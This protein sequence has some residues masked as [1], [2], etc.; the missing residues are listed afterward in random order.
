[1]PQNKKHNAYFIWI[2]VQLPNNDKQWYCVS[3]VL[4]HALYWERDKN[5][6]KYWKNSLIGNYIN[7]ATSNYV[8]NQARLTVGKVLK[9]RIYSKRPQDWHWTRN[10]FISEDSLLHFRSAYNYMKHN[11]SWYNRISIW[12]A[13]QHWHIELLQKKINNLKT[14]SRK[15]RGKYMY[16]NKRKKAH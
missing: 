2:L 11:Y 4:R 7:V 15:F 12:F 14:K 3:K 8:H 9:I 1:M 16:P 10:Q 13:L 5:Q 6:N